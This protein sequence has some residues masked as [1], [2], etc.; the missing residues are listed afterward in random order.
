MILWLRFRV[1]FVMPCYVIEVLHVL[2]D[3]CYFICVVWSYRCVVVEF[4]D[5]VDVCCVP[6]WWRWRMSWEAVAFLTSNPE[7]LQERSVSFIYTYTRAADCSTVLAKTHL[8]TFPCTQNPKDVWILTWTLYIDY[9]VYFCWLNILSCDFNTC[10]RAHSCNQFCF[11][12]CFG[13]TIYT[14]KPI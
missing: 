3:L 11:W 7:Y 4:C 13:S 8:T 2:R 14:Y 5:C 6:G 10:T 1:S 12:L 9:W